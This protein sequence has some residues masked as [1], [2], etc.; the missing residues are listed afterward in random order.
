MDQTQ[1][2]STGVWLAFV[3][4]LCLVSVN[5]ARRRRRAFQ[6]ELA[7]LRAGQY[8][9]LVAYQ[10]YAQVNNRGRILAI[11]VIFLVLVATIG[12]V[13]YTGLTTPDN[14][15]GLGTLLAEDYRL[16]YLLLPLPLFLPALTYT[17]LAAVWADAP[18]FAQLRGLPTRPADLVALRLKSYTVNLLPLALIMELAAV[19]YALGVGGWYCF[20]GAFIVVFIDISV[21][22][23]IGPVLVRWYYPAQPIEQTPWA[24]WGDRARAWSQLAGVPIHRVYVRST[25]PFGLA[26]GAT[27]GRR[28]QTLFLSDVFLQNSDWRQR[29]ALI[30]LLLAVSDRRRRGAQQRRQQRGQRGQSGNT[31][32]ISGPGLLIFVGVIVGVAMLTAFSSQIAQGLPFPI[33]L[34]LLINLLSLLVVI[35]L[36][37]LFARQVQLNLRARRHGPPANNV[38]SA[39]D[40]V[41]VALCGDPLALMAAILG[42]NLLSGVVLDRRYIAT[43]PSALDRIHAIEQSLLQPGPY[44]PWAAQPIPAL[45]P[46]QMGPYT[47][48][49]PITPAAI[50]ERPGPVPT[51]RY[52]VTLSPWAA[53]PMMATPYA[54][55]MPAPPSLYDSS[56]F[57]QPVAYPPP[58]AYT[59]VMAYTPIPQPAPSAGYTPATAAPPAA[60]PAE[61]P[62][63][64]MPPPELP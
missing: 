62:W 50:A 30:C 23:R 28:P 54:A 11:R 4:L 25:A 26:D 29:D 60:Q 19:C 15:A 12:Y 24:E 3:A 27:S 2:V 16:F 9:P 43:L 64:A 57:P 34:T 5:N 49:A 63:T 14:L 53:T 55:P 56:Q 45:T 47:M 8:P 51:L 44:A 32:R 13:V 17:L 48:S 40:A 41:A 39:S 46:V 21:I 20:I 38:Y 58:E 36:F 33:D 35:L 52:P 10:R 37:I 31:V 7:A 59:P 18:A 6:R 1:L 22:T 61:S 42:V